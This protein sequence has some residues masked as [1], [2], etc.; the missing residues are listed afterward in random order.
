[1]KPDIHTA[2]FETKCGGS[3]QTRRK[4]PNEIIHQTA[5]PGARLNT[6]AS[7]RSSSDR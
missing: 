3:G 6:T 2:A 4:L 5:P 7:L 1:M